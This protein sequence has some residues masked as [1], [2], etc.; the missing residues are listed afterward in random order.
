MPVDES[1][2]TEERHREDNEREES[3]IDQS[4][5]ETTTIG[6][7]DQAPQGG[8]EESEQ[9]D[10]ET[11]RDPPNNGEGG[12]G[13]PD[14]EDGDTPPPSDDE[15]HLL[16][17]L[18]FIE[19][20]DTVF[21][22]SGFQSKRLYEHTIADSDD[23]SEL[24]AELKGPFIRNQRDANPFELTAEGRE[25]VRQAEDMQ[26]TVSEQLAAYITDAVSDDQILQ[27]LLWLADS[28]ENDFSWYLQEHSGQF[29]EPLRFLPVV[30]TDETIQARLNIRSVINRLGSLP[31]EVYD[32]ISRLLEDESYLK[33]LATAEGEAVAEL[34]QINTDTAIRC[35]DFNEVLSYYLDESRTDTV[36]RDLKQAGIDID[37]NAFGIDLDGLLSQ[38]RER[39][40]NWLSFDRE[41]CQTAFETYWDLILEW[42]RDFPGETVAMKQQLVDVGAAIPQ[43]RKLAVRIEAFDIAGE[44]VHELQTVLQDRLDDAEN[45]SS[46]IFFDFEEAMEQ[47]EEI[48]VIL[49]EKSWSSN[50]Y[51]YPAFISGRDRSDPEQ[52]I[53]TKKIVLVPSPRELGFSDDHL[54]QDRYHCHGRAV[55]SPE[56]NRE[57]NAIG[58]VDGLDA[59][60]NE[61]DQLEW[62]QADDASVRRAEELI[63]QREQIS[64]NEAFDK[65]AEYEPPFQEALY[66]LAAKRT[67]GTSKKRNNY[68][69]DVLWNDVNNMLEIRYP[70]LSESE[71]GE[72][73]DT[74]RRILVDRAGIDLIKFSEEEQ[75]HSR[76]GDQFDERIEERISNLSSEDQRLVTT[77]LHGW[78]SEDTVRPEFDIHP[79]FELYHEFWFGEA[80]SANQ[81]LYD[82]LVTTGICSPA[83]YVTSHS[84]PD[85]K[86]VYAVYEGVQQDTDRFLAATTTKPE[87][88]DIEVLN[89]Y[90]EDIPQLAGIEYLIENNGSTFRSDLRDQLFSLDDGAW[91][92][93]KMVDRVLAEK[94]DQIVLNPLIVDEI[95]DWLTEAKRECVTNIE[96]IKKRLRQANVIDLKLDF[97]TD[98]RIYEGYVLTRE[99]EKIQVIVAPWLIEDE[100][101]WIDPPSIVIITS[102]YYQRVLERHRNG[103]RDLLIIGLADDEFE[104]YRSLP[105]QK[106]AEPI[107]QAFESDYVLIK[108]DVNVDTDETASDIHSAGSTRDQDN[109][110]DEKK[111]ATTTDESA[112]SSTPPSLGPSSEDNV[113]L[114]GELFNQPDAAFPSEVLRDRP[115]IIILHET[116]QDRFGTTMQLLCRELY[117]QFE[118]GLPRG[119]IRGD[120]D[121]IERR[122]QAG[123]RIEFIDQSDGEF[124]DHTR[125]P[126][127]AVTGNSVQWSKIRR[128]IQELDTQGLG[129]LLFQLPSEYASEFRRDLVTRVR[130]HRPQIIELE[131]RLPKDEYGTEEGYYDRAIPTAD[132]LWGYPGLQNEFEVHDPTSEFETFDDMFTLAERRAWSQLHTGITTPIKSET[133]K[134]SP[135][136]VV[137][138]HQVGDTGR[139]NESYLH[140][141]LKVFTVRWLI[142]TEGYTFNSVATETD[143]QLAQRTNEGLIPDVQVG[144]TVFEIETLY[145]TGTPVLAIK[146]TIEKYQERSNL[147]RIQLILPPI[148]GFLHYSDLT[149]LAHEINDAWNLEVSLLIPRLESKEVISIEQLR[150]TIEGRIG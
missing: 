143:T 92:S 147:S 2:E 10:P 105:H 56:A 40:A 116:Q 149:Y 34:L 79:E 32:E 125:G 132:A 129:F 112:A 140:Y 62:E 21:E 128:R 111:T 26:T 108:R 89:E 23:V 55:E 36:I 75:V 103:F 73:K 78:G 17:F 137:Q 131:P 99:N 81:S 28:N 31:D 86:Q 14:G 85:H 69:E 46:Q 141:A 67:T 6:G 20:N 63:K 80:T 117:H 48:L 76:F 104:V 93:F 11:D 49:Y 53:F 144:D 130:P 127:N 45:V 148:A 98:R 38:H 66:T 42:N 97:N 90:E 61:F 82:L 25:Q 142:E 59:V 50:Q 54:E 146:E 74:L 33:G 72:I 126:G 57:F 15:L 124:F 60:K 102:E 43:G 114:V 122:L 94:D 22:L 52:N 4:G 95:E 41:A 139:G 77:F 3:V 134:K 145:G 58:E 12:D 109:T 71:R 150:R 88:L 84:N 16:T 91:M 37:R 64:L 9:D 138:P 123:N 65:I 83:T 96:G 101:I 106:I 110:T 51:H 35:S 24:Y 47:D 27:R 18:W 19:R 119:R 7:N 5:S 100:E 29:E 133:I 30:F 118:G 68:T 44:T 136:M 13:D 8:V 70:S 135:A 107:I 121:D 115:L 120:A 113:D 87:L 39:L 1:R